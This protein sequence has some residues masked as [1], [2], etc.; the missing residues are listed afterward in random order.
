MPPIQ[1][2]AATRTIAMENAIIS[3]SRRLQLLR[4]TY[5]FPNLVAKA[6]ILRTGTKA[7]VLI[8]VAPRLRLSGIVF[9]EGANYGAMALVKSRVRLAHAI[10]A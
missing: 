6:N 1:I 5:L 9:V 10:I 8:G 2:P 3:R 7:G 4:D